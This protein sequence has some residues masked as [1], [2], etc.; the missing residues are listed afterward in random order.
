ML[1]IIG[2][3]IIAV[4]ILALLGIVHI[5][6]NIAIILIVVGVLLVVFGGGVAGWGNWGRRPP[7]P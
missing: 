1:V 7:T 6:T 3:I 4:A 2:L 5:A